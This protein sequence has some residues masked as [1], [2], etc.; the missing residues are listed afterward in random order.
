MNAG[1]RGPKGL[2]EPEYALNLSPHSKDEENEEVHDENG[3][4][5][6]NVEAF[7]QSAESGNEGRSC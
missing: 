5:N 6:G 3:P 7:G 1:I 2:A 4:V